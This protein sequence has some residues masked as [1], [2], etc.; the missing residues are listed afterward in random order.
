MP[1]GGDAGTLQ[2]TRHDDIEAEKPF[3]DTAEARQDV[4]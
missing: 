4:I 2:I 3:E 1:E